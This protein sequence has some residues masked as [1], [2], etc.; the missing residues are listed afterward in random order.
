M[1]RAPHS[2]PQLPPKKNRPLVYYDGPLQRFSISTSCSVRDLHQISRKAH[3]KLDFT[4]QFFFSFQTAPF[5]KGIFRTQQLPIAVLVLNLNAPRVVAV[6]VFSLCIFGSVFP[7]ADLCLG[8]AKIKR[9]FWCRPGC[10]CK[11]RNAVQ[12]SA[13]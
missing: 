7:L 12:S 9:A 1:C 5:R 4:F 3:F 6:L 10:L 13:P 2:S 8:A 11:W